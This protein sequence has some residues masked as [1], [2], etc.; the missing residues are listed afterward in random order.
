MSRITWLR[1]VVP[2][3]VF[4]LSKLPVPVIIVVYLNKEPSEVVFDF[5]D[6]WKLLLSKSQVHAERHKTRTA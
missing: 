3:V 4:T 5:S 6:L 2:V 1:V